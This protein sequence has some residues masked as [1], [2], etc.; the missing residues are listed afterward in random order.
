MLRGTLLLALLLALASPASAVFIAGEMDAVDTESLFD[1]EYFL[2][3]ESFG[4]PLDWHW[5]WRSSSAGYR[6]NGAS[7]DRSDLLLSQEVRLGKP[8]LDWLAF[9]YSLVH[10]GDKDLQALHQRVAFELGPFKGLTAGIFGEPLFAKE[11]SDVGAL[12]RYSP[13]P[14]LTL[15]ASALAV[16]FEFNARGRTTQ[17][18]DRKPYTFDTGV[19]LDLAEDSLTASAEFDSPLSRRL[20]DDGRVYRYRRTRLNARWD[21][22]PA[23]GV[24]SWSGGYSCEFKREGDVYSPDPSALS[25]DFRRTVH[26][27]DASAQRPLGPR[28]RLE[29]G[30]RLMTRSARAELHSAP[31]RSS[32]YRRWEL[33]PHARWRRDLRS[34]LVSELALFASGGE[35]RRLYDSAAAVS[36]T[37]TP[38]EGKLGTGLD[39]VYGK[40]GRIGLY[41]TWD[42]DDADRHVW[43]GGNV[44]A[45][46][47]F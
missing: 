42:I 26:T 23:A 21:R 9:R 39:L 46:F 33:L 6:V 37:E 22:S 13:L 30:L 17:R 19:R 16:D 35:R 34:W 38:M 8:L 40:G 47:L 15:F 45:M 31:V 2:D 14:P 36:M 10:D 7:L 1:S 12:L 11:D 20:P 18:Y 41:G 28:D 29:A 25:Q 24:W 43:D 5:A 32:G 27:A 3:L 44:R 4:Y